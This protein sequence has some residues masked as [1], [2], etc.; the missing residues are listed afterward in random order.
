MT[1]LGYILDLDLS[2]RDGAD[3]GEGQERDTAAFF[4]FKFSL[5]SGTEDNY[6]ESEAREQVNK[7]IL[8]RNSE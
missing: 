3:G 8:R 6:V 4:G 5:Q 2:W 7:N 1:G